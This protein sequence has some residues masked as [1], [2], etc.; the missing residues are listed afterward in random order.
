[1]GIL[2]Y[3]KPK[4]AKVLGFFLVLIIFQSVFSSELKQIQ[5]LDLW[6]FSPLDKVSVVFA[7]EIITSDSL[8]IINFNCNSYKENFFDVNL[9]G[10]YSKRILIDC[11][12]PFEKIYLQPLQ[13]SERI[14]IIAEKY[15]D[16]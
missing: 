4:T 5:F 16:C 1:M 14:Q 2:I 9:T 11:T 10:Y 13:H 12:K 3:H 8:G 15:D 7:N 6:D